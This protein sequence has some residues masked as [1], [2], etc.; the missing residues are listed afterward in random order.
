V[1]TYTHPYM[2]TL[3]NERVLAELGYT[4]QIIHD[5]TGG[6]VPKYWRPPFGDVDNRVRAI[7]RE[8]FDLTTVVWNQDSA[9]W[10][11]TYNEIPLTQVEASLKS[12]YTGKKS[13]GLVILEH[14]L[15]NE[16]VEAFIYS[17]P[18]MQAN[19]WNPVT[20]PDASRDPTRAWYFNSINDTD[21]VLPEGILPSTSA[22][23]QVGSSTSSTT[24][25]TAGTTQ[26]THSSATPPVTPSHTSTL[27]NSAVTIQP[28]LSVGPFIG[29]LACAVMGGFFPL[30]I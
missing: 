5:S 11:L 25:G 17:W 23:T 3:S 20:I 1:H 21:G 8:V 12:F 16:S 19:G 29:I 22:S 10:L 7:A 14:E 2:T 13:P 24:S 30:A 4:M 28:M 15:S 18:I 9:D 27:P 26:R 6:R